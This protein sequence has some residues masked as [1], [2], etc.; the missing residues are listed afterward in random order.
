ML[1]KLIFKTQHLKIILA[2]DK[3]TKYYNINR[4]NNENAILLKNMKRF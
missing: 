1:I 3:V 4:I 2:E